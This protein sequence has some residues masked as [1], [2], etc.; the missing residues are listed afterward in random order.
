MWNTQ[1]SIC[2]FVFFQ[3]FSLFLKNDIYTDCT[4]LTNTNQKTKKIK[5]PNFD[6]ASSHPQNN[7]HTK[8]DTNILKNEKQI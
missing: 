4:D 6:N 7:S 8:H 2:L 5:H 1:K 3:I